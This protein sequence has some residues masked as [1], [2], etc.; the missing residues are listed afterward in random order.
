MTII[1]CVLSGPPGLVHGEKWSG[2]EARVSRH[3]AGQ[4]VSSKCSPRFCL[5]ALLR[6]SLDRAYSAAAYAQ[7]IGAVSCLQAKII[8]F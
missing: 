4:P 2:G 3:P 5:V 8:Q 1:V 7:G 6:Q